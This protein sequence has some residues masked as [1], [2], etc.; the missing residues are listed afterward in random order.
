M[1]KKVTLKDI[2]QKTGVTAA[3]VSMILNGKELSRFTPETVSRVLTAAREMQYVTPA[4]KHT[5]KQIA[6]IS[7]SV[8]NP[9]HTTIIMGIERAAL[10]SGYLT[11][12]YNTYWNP[13]TELVLLQQLEMRRVAGIIYVMNPLQV[14]KAREVDGHIPVVAVGDIVSHLGI[15][16]VDVNNFRAGEIVAKHL[17]DLGHK[18]IAYLTTSLNDHHI[19]R[20]RRCEGLQDT[21]RRL[22]PEGSVTVF[23]KENELE[24]ELQSPD[25]ELESGKELAKA[26]LTHPEITGIVAINDMVGFGVLDGLLEAGMRVP[27]DYSLCGFDNVFPTGFQRMQMTT[28]DHGTIYHGARAFHLLKDK[29]EATERPAAAYPITRVEYRSKLVQRGSTAPPRTQK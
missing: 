1:A 11:A 7:P 16:T 14:E 29:M 8:N 15:D 22:C 26:C 21:F 9:Y 25:I 6:I 4:E 10:S 5:P 20:V 13:Q 12:T 28:V 19:A 23:C 3:S 24:Q 27:E 18:H 2:A 17:I